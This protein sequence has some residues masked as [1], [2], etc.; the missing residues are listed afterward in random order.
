MNQPTDNATDSG[1]SRN[2]HCGDE[3]SD[4]RQLSSVTAPDKIRIA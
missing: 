1:L 3:R 4:L 2:L